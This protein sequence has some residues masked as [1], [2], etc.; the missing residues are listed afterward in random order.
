MKNLQDLITELK[1]AQN[2]EE[3]KAVEKELHK[4]TAI[5]EIEHNEYKDHFEIIVWLENGERESWTVTLEYEPR[6]SQWWD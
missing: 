6:A 4:I 3:F 5:D 1:N 2:Y